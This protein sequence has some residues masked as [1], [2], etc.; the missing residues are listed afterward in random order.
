[1]LSAMEEDVDDWQDLSVDS[2]DAMKWIPW[3]ISLDGHEFLLEVEESFIQDQFNLCGLKSMKNYDSAMEMILGYAPTEEV[4]MDASFLQ[5]YRCASDLYGMIHARF[6]TSP[7]GLQL[8]KEKFQQGVFGHCP[9]VRCQRQN[10]L[11]VGFSDTLHN[12]RI[13]KYCPRCQEAYLFK[14]NEAHAEIDGA[15]IG[16]SFPHIFLLSFPHLIPKDPPQPYIPRIFGFRVHKINSLIKIKLDNGEFG[17]SPSI[18][19][20]SQYLSQIE[21]DSDT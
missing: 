9:R 12:H 6:I 20:E 10:V 4:F 13:K 17:A 5:L 8:M 3:F 21:D 14:S 2:D 15:F 11:P 1:M 18:K 7:M 19:H 16:R